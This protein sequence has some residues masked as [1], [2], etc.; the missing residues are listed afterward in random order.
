MARQIH[1]LIVDD[2]PLARQAIAQILASAEDISV[3]G[4]ASDGDEAVE[5]VHKHRPDVVLMDL[6]MKRMDGISASRAVKQ[7]PEAPHVIVLTSWDV[8]DAV[9]RSLR[10]GAAGFL[11]K[12][13]SP[14]EIIAAVRNVASGDA[15]LSPRSTRQLLDYVAGAEADEEQERAIALVGSLSTREREV[16]AAVAEGKTNSAIASALFLSLATVK[17]HVNAIQRKLGVDNR[18]GVAV[19]AERARIAAGPGRK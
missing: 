17:T 15:V 1:V 18:V 3:T 14:D 8:N 4:E 5:A 9:V 19:M 7:C 2:D 16:A 12:T 6:R 13:S 10:V 11:L